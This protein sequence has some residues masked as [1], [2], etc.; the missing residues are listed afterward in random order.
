M[1]LWLQSDGLSLLQVLA[2]HAKGADAQSPT[3]APFA[4]EQASSRPKLDLFSPYPK[5]QK[6]EIAF[7]SQDMEMTVVTG[8]LLE[9]SSPYYV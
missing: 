2:E 7:A 3:L 6:Q 4:E 5:G 1:A 8:L 9:I